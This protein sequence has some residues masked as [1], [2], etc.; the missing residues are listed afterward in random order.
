MDKKTWVILGILVVGVSALIGVS[1]WQSKSE[2]TNYSSYEAFAINQANDDTGNYAE[3]IE[4]NPN[5]P[6][7]MYQYGNYQC[8]ACAPM[9]PYINQLK[10]EYGDNLAIVFRH[11]YLPS[12]SNATAAAAAA[13]AAA[14]QGYWVEFKDL[15]FANQNDWFYSDAENRQA[16]FEDY[17]NKAS[18]GKGDLE[19]FR[20]D[21]SS[22][23]VQKKIDYDDAMAEKA[24]ASF[25]PSFYVED[26]FIGQRR[27]DNDGKDLTTEQ[28]LDKLRA[29][30]DKRLEAK[31]I[32][33]E[34]KT[35]DKG[36]SSNK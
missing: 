31:G 21:M 3:N 15:V 19:Q 32:K 25:T 30:I 9:N 13:N 34:K 28:F 20:K 12:H 35:A 6:V 2:R 1:I 11:M 33:I 24:G 23:E 5:A 10:K 14:K 17:F 16:Q 8:T 22:K 27:E 26:E 36:S 29:A 4:G 7:I 18:D